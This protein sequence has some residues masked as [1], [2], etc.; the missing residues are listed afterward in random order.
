MQK[1][2]SPCVFAEPMWK[3]SSTHR[4]MWTIATCTQTSHWWLVIASRASDLWVVTHFSTLVFGLCGFALC[5]RTTGS[6][7]RDRGCWMRAWNGKLQWRTRFGL[8]SHHASDD[9]KWVSPSM[10]SPS[11]LPVANAHS[12]RLVAAKPDFS[13]DLTGGKAK[14]AFE[15]GCT[16]KWDERER[17]SVWL[18]GL[19]FGI[20]R[21]SRRP[22]KMESFCAN[23]VAVIIA[24]NNASRLVCP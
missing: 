1:Y 17:E 9:L 5:T 21:S 10:T 3:L 20:P 18:L 12:I 15:V 14:V 22:L 13:I 19:G 24:L 16:S 7:L 2:H 6:V 23:L 8:I 4:T 11:R